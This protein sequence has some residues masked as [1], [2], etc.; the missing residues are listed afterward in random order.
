MVDVSLWE[1]L[2]QQVK[3]RQQHGAH[4]PEII[5]ERQI[6]EALAIDTLDD[7]EEVTRHEDVQGTL[8]FLLAEDVDE[9]LKVDGVVAEHEL[10]DG[11][12]LCLRQH[13]FAHAA[14]W[15]SKDFVEKDF[16]HARAVL[17]QF[18]LEM[19]AVFRFGTDRVN[20]ELDVGLPLHEH[21]HP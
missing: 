7:I 12:A 17:R 8:P 18:V 3:E 10:V 16:L 1:L 19:A 4:R 6:V 13:V 20:D 21:L 5:R 14:R 2:L 15:Q 9:R 11:L